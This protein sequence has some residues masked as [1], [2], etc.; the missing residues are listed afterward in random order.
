MEN[1]QGSERARLNLTLT[2]A[3]I[4]TSLTGG[5]V[6]AT[7]KGRDPEGED[8]FARF[9]LPQNQSLDDLYR[10][11]DK[12]SF[13]GS[14][15]LEGFWKTRRF[16]DAERIERT[17]LE[18]VITDLEPKR[19]AAIQAGAVTQ[20]PPE[21]TREIA[22]KPAA[23]AAAPDARKASVALLA[24]SGDLDSA[25]LQIR[26][27]KPAPGATPVAMALATYADAIAQPQFEPAGDGK[28][29]RTGEVLSGL[30]ALDALK[31]DFGAYKERNVYIDSGRAGEIAAGL[32]KGADILK[33]AQ[34][35]TAERRSEN[36]A[37]K[38]PAESPAKA[39]AKGKRTPPVAAKAEN[40]KAAESGKATAA[41]KAKDSP[42]SIAHQ[43]DPLILTA[44][45]GEIK[46]AMTS[47]AGLNSAVASTLRTFAAAVS[48]PEYRAKSGGG[49]EKTGKVF[50][51]VSGLKMTL[52]GFGKG[53]YRNIM[54]DKAVVTDI[55][56]AM[57]DTSKSNGAMAAALS[58]SQ[59]RREEMGAARNAAKAKT[60]QRERDRD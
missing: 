5:D 28:F 45:A 58:A 1:D 29:K 37:A 52:D 57:P 12:A 10:V 7:F 33:E 34:S 31:A 41:P 8:R 23:E 30:S 15:D 6:V 24:T 32:G 60:K 44:S 42:S 39:D 53:A 40:P 48:Q 22:P 9:N 2:E 46:A 14:V 4:I 47:K 27:G 50:K 51:G 38:A 13:E 11:A 3:P 17:R 35:L 18:F 19:E 49:F 43:S 54:L 20:A 59:G 36:R 26:E 25:I 56:M 55:M 16:Q 21:A